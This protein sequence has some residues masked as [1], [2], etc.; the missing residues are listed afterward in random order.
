M[1]PQVEFEAEG[2]EHDFRFGCYFPFKISA[3]DA[4]AYPFKNLNGSYTQNS[5]Q[6]LFQTRRSNLIIKIT[7]SCRVEIRK[8]AFDEWIGGYE[9]V[10]SAFAE[11]RF[12]RGS[13]LSSKG[14]ML[15]QR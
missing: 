10:V 1:T 3:Q 13:L 12:Q 6:H 8:P 15:E 5:L 9:F 11:D 7:V 2:I 14:V 4:T